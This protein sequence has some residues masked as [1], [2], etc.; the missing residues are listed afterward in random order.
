MEN[1]IERIESK[2][3]LITLVSA[4]ME[5]VNQNHTG[6]VW[7]WSDDSSEGGY[8]IPTV[9]RDGEPVVR[10]YEIR[11]KNI[12]RLFAALEKLI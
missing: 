6:K 11:Q 4:I 8:F 3:D 9:E 10:E 5:D 7:R 12:E 2:K 1:Y